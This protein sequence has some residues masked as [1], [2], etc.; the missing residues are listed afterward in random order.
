[1]ARDLR[2]DV[3]RCAEAVQPEPLGVAG[4]PQR[5]IAD[6]TGAEEGRAADR[7]EVRR[8]RIAVALVRERVLGVAAVAVVT[9]ELRAVAEVLLAGAAVAAV[10]VGPTEPRNAD[11]TPFADDLA[12]DLVADH[13]RQLRP[14]QLAVDD[15][16]IRPADTACL[17]ANDEL[18]RSGGRLR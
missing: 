15:V 10:A 9:R 5:A 7:E 18:A 4:E 2:D 14:S 12:D 3:R 8:Q 6:Q 1:M 11:A 13:E 17:D 16:E